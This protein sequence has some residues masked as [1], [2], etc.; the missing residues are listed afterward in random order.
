MSQKLIYVVM[1]TVALALGGC[2]TMGNEGIKDPSK[3]ALIIENKTTDTQAR[4]ILGDPSDA[5]TEA[6]GDKIWTYEMATGMVF[7]TNVKSVVL[8][9]RKGVVIAKDESVSKGSLF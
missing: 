7:G 4:A 9:I 6:N 8:R 3:L 2:V 1:I 5:R